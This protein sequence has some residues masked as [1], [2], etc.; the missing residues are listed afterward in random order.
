MRVRTVPRRMSVPPTR[1]ADPVSEQLL[2]LPAMQPPP[3]EAVTYAD[4]EGLEN[5]A[6]CRD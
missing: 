5:T 3:R 2:E 6:C 1:T 4:Q